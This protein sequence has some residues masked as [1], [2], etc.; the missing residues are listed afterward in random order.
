VNIEEP[1]A[2]VTSASVMPL[3]S[4]LRNPAPGGGG[5]VVVVAGGPDGPQAASSAA[6]KSAPAHVATDLAAATVTSP[7]A[8][9]R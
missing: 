9:L 8:G 3:Q 7:T 4:A 2:F 5:G 1:T 6:A